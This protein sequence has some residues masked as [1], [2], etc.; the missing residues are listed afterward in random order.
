[1]PG[2]SRRLTVPQPVHSI[3]GWA[4]PRLEQSTQYLASGLHLGCPQAQQIGFSAGEVLDQTDSV[5]MGGSM[6]G[7][8][9]ATDTPSRVATDTPR[10]SPPTPGVATDTPSCGLSTTRWLRVRSQPAGQRSRNR[11]RLGRPQ[12]GV[13]RVPPCCTWR[14][15]SPSSCRA[16]MCFL[17][18]R[19]VTP[20]YLARV[21]TDGQ[22]PPSPSWLAMPTRTSLAA[23]VA[24]L[25]CRA[26]AM[27]STL[28]GGPFRLSGSPPRRHRTHKRR[29]GPGALRR[30]LD[31]HPRPVAA[32]GGR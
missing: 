10:V 12:S 13:L 28:T 24:R 1:M 3:Q 4:K 19:G 2:V 25:W 21:A 11:Y 6:D 9:V 31:G 14:S 27:D 16:S 18:F 22:A 30:P 5:F 26:M 17:T 15:I 23:P 7:S 29:V 32:P 8:G 20:A